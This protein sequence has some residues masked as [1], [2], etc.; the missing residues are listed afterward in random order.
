MT[1]K[2]EDDYSTLPAET[3]KKI[4]DEKQKEGSELGERLLDLMLRQLQSNRCVEEINEILESRESLAVLIE[5]EQNKFFESFQLRKENPPQSKMLNSE[6]EAVEHK[7]LNV[8]K[9][10]PTNEL[11]SIYYNLDSSQKLSLFCITHK[12]E[13]YTFHE[14][15]LSSLSESERVMIIEMH[16]ENEEYLEKVMN[17]EIP[18]ESP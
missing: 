15:L 11:A 7:I 16:R 1:K 14:R 2:I 8:I 4:R 17:G 9:N 10:T 6:A 12:E 3:L 18:K 5:N 13:H